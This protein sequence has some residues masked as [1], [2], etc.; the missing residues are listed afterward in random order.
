MDAGLAD[1][2]E[3]DT[4]T[5]NAAAAAAAA[6]A[7]ASSGGS[8]LDSELEAALAGVAVGP[9]RAETR[10]PPPR[11]AAHQVPAA[12]AAPN[13]GAVPT[14]PALSPASTAR[15]VAI[16]THATELVASAARAVAAS[17]AAGAA[18]RAP[19]AGRA[20]GG[21]ETLAFDA[22]ALLASLRVEGG[23]VGAPQPRPRAGGEPH[24]AGEAA[25]GGVMSPQAAAR[26]RQYVGAYGG[27]VAG[28]DAEGVDAAAPAR[29]LPS[30]LQLP[31][32][33]GGGG[34]KGDVYDYEL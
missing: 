13:T 31:M 34:G 17:T 19:L 3:G 4:G 27:E 23:S 1:E 26:Y 18:T 22:S 24:R 14:P 30:S 32:A 9:R 25:G 5:S 15:V 2:E 33:G 10:L 21:R 16:R 11:A 7:T 29:P 8:A 20:L 6:L 28:D 12:G